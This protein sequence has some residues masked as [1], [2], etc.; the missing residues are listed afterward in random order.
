M[1]NLDNMKDKNKK[2]KRGDYKTKEDDI[3]KMIVFLK[4][5]KIKE[6]GK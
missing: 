6:L 4:A 3:L 5:E 1:V 2:D